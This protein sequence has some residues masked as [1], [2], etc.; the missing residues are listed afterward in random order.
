MIETAKADKER[1]GDKPGRFVAMLRI[2]KPDGTSRDV[3]V[4]T[5]ISAAQLFLDPP[6]TPNEV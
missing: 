5:D 3:E 4:E 1:P 2:T 6:T